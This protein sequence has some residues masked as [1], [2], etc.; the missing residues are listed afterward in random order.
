MM[1]KE[2]I[3]K[4]EKDTKKVANYLTGIITDAQ[5]RRIPLRHAELVKIQEML[6]RASDRL[7]EL[8]N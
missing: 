7:F 3:I 1:M 6:D 8:L 4:A 5:E 2:Q